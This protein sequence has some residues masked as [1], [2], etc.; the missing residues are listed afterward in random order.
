VL[1]SA[2][3]HAALQSDQGCDEVHYLQA[4]A[5]LTKGY[6]GTRRLKA[7]TVMFNCIGHTQQHPDN[8]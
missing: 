6:A 3:R 7:K 4:R 8:A 2:D 1:Q 5:E